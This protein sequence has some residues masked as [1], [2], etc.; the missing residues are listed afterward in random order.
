MSARD[1]ALE[2]LRSKDPSAVVGQ[3][4]RPGCCPLSNMLRE[5]ASAPDPAVFQRTYRME[6]H[7]SR[8]LALGAWAQAA[9]AAVDAGG[10]RCQEVTAAEA[11]RAWEAIADA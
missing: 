5:R 4:G 11:L 1:T 10:P 6:R 8:T 9:V 3:R 2:W 7:A